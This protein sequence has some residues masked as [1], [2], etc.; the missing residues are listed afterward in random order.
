M[1]SRRWRSRI[2]YC[3]KPKPVQKRAGRPEGRCDADCLRPCRKTE[4]ESVSVLK[5]DVRNWPARQALLDALQAT[6]MVKAEEAQSP[7]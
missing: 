7:R 6:A 5:P 4:D 1:I 3:S 2:R